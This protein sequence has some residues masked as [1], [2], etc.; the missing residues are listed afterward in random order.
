MNVVAFRHP[1]PRFP[2]GERTEDICVAEG[3]SDVDAISFLLPDGELEV[4]S[5]P[6][7]V[8]IDGKYG[9]Y[10]LVCHPM[11]GGIIVKRSFLLRTGLY[12][13]VEYLVFATL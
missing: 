4:E 6:A 11:E 1:S 2:R 3:Y 8:V 5:M 10:S 12:D 9:T 13:K 7:S